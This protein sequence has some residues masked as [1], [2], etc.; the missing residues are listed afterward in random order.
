MSDLLIPRHIAI[1]MDGNN[2]YGKAQQLA[3]GEGHVAGKD[4]LDPVVEHCLAAGVEVL[5]VFAFSSEN[6]QRPA[7]E[8]ALLMRLLSATIYEQMPRMDKYHIRLRFIGD[9]TPLSPQLQTLM[10]EAEAKTAH[11]TAMTLVIAISYGG[12]WDIAQAARNLAQQ[13]QQGLL[14][15]DEVD[16]AHLAGQLQ[17]ADLPVV[18]MLIR[19]GGEYR[20]SNFLL[21]QVAYAELF[22]TDTLWPSFGCDELQRMLA[23]FAGRQR[24]FGKTSEQITQQAV[25]QTSLQQ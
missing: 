3:V 7:S 10:A 25:E 18:D 22:F 15:C 13:V 17:L 6:W 20:L 4:A 19:T 11:F 21:W 8:V 23:E 14:S 24:R 12:R 9:R 2:R 16:E 5:T 1:I